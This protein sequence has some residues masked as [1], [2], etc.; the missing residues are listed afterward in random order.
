MH[1]A[2]AGPCRRRRGATQALLLTAAA[3]VLLLLVACPCL[4]LDNTHDEAAAFVAGAASP[5]GAGGSDGQQGSGPQTTTGGRPIRVLVMPSPWRSR[6]VGPIKTALELAKRGH[7]VSILGRPRR[8][9]MPRQPQRQ[10]RCHSPSSS[11]VSGA[12]MCHLRGPQVLHAYMRCSR[13]LAVMATA[14]QHPHT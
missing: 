8:H 13:H 9:P 10:L 14:T 5:A 4:C 12:R 11:P 1:P 3:A 2:P 7:R 6:A